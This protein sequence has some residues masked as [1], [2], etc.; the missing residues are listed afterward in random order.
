MDELLDDLQRYHR[1]LPVRASAPSILR[2]SG[3]FLRRHPWSSGLAA[4]L[5]LSLAVAAIAMLWQV[6]RTERARANAVSQVQ[7]LQALREQMLIALDASQSDGRSVSEVL[8]EQL[9]PA[10]STE[11]AARYAPQRA[12]A[13]LAL[14]ELQFVAGNNQRAAELL[15]PLLTRSELNPSSRFH[16]LHTQLQIDI[17]LNQLDAA[18]AH[19][20]QLEAQLQSLRE[21]EQSQLGLLKLAQ[22]Q[23]ARAQGQLPQSLTLQREGL[24]LLRLAPDYSPLELGIAESNL[25]AALLQAGQF[26]AAQ[27]SYVQAIARWQAAGLAHTGNALTARTNL[28]HLAQLQGQFHAALEFYAD[29]EAGFRA[30][31]STSAAFAALLIAKARALLALEQLEPARVTA[32]EAEAVAQRAS[33][34]DSSDALGAALASLD[35]AQALW[36]SASQ[37]ERAELSAAYALAFARLQQ[38]TIGLP[39]AH[40]FL[41]RLNLNQA[42]AQQLSGDCGT[43]LPALRTL[44]QAFSAASA[45]Q[46][47]SALRAGVWAS[48]CALTLGQAATA[49]QSITELEPLFAK[50]PPDSA[51]RLEVR[52][53]TLVL[54]PTPD[55]E[56]IAQTRRALARALSPGSS[57]LIQ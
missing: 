3:L 6:Q 8:S 52:L 9:E 51:H 10:Q 53:W 17:R 21:P 24:A 48:Q 20:Q 7:R 45:T 36:A 2:R 16:A 50:Q 15:A 40:P 55:A 46:H 14:A 54:A 26:D 27:A 39:P 28:G 13:E 33:G 18:K 38:R 25:G 37:S 47:P 11:A 1:H 29:A 56:R 23:L 32:L 31:K 22:A 34:A 57:R 43:A 4:T 35:V 42:R 41:L 49:R 44:Q 12:E 5:L 30:R 19:V